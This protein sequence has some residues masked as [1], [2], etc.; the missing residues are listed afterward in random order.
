MNSERYQ[1]SVNNLRVDVI[2]K[3]IKH[4]HLAVYPPDG[5]VR[6]SVPLA[7]S[8]EAVRLA[9]IDKLGW[10][11]RKQAKMRDQPR[12]SSREMVTGESHYFQ[13]RRYLLNV[14][15][16]DGH[17]TVS[18][19][20]NRTMDLYVRPGNG[21]RT[22]GRASAGSATGNGSEIMAGAGAEDAAGRARRLAILR[23]WYREQLH[24]QIP[25]LIAKWEPIVGADV[26]EWRIKRM[27]TRWGTCNT[28]ARR[29]WLNLELAK[30]PVNCLEFVLVHEMVHLHERL[31]NERFMAY[32]D[33]FMPQW[34]LHRAELNRRPLV[35]EDWGY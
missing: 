10:I 20:G 33:R 11:H 23:R 15:E 22:G 35:H 6:V 14:I 2:R 29:V 8:D 17:E 7:V 16:T 13:G 32:M 18:L 5:R 30:K 1:I 27:K 34:R 9:V 21:A 28:Q 3:R 25:G 19:N 26:A 24:D 31:H 4:L 12:Q